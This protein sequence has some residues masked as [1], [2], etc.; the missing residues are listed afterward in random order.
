MNGGSREKKEGGGGMEKGK[1]GWQGRGMVEK[2]EMG[3]MEKV[4]V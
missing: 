2:V 1:E 3:R 4:E